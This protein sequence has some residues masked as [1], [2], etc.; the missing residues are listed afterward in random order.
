MSQV[1]GTLGGIGIA[2]VSGFGIYGLLR[3]RVGIRLTEKEEHEG[4][5]SAVHKIEPDGDL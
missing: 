5:D 1:V 2:I 3:A 4:A